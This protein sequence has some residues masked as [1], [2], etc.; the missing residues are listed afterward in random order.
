MTENLFS[1]LGLDC[2]LLP[3]KFRY[4]VYGGSG[5]RFEGVRIDGYTP[6]E[7]VF[8]VR[9]G[10]LLVKGKNMSVKKYIENEVSLVGEIFAVELV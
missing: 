10:K 5:G 1:S 8:S 7:V 4:Q 6:S 2:E 9:G 3:Y